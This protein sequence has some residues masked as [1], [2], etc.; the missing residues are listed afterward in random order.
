[1][2]DLAEVLAKKRDQFGDITTARYLRPWGRAA[3]LI[4]FPPDPS[5]KILGS[6]VGETTFQPGDLVLVGSI[7]GRRRRVVLGFPPPG[8]GGG[9]AFALGPTS[10]GGIDQPTLVAASPSPIPAGAVDFELF[11]I[12]TRFASEEPFDIFAATIRDP[13]TGEESPDPYV[14]V[15]G[16]PEFIADPAAEGLIV[17][18]TQTVVRVLVDVDAAAPYLPPLGPWRISFSVRRP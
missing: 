4:L 8:M 10:E 17:L 9:G 6:A 3:H 7:A 13:V 2:K 5:P 1:M 14:T 12:G 18:E 11:L 15:H 16:T